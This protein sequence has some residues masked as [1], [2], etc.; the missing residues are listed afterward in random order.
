M[1]LSRL[2]K[3]AGFSLLEMGIVLLIIGMVAGSAAVLMNQ[4]LE[5]AQANETNQKMQ[6]IQKTLLDFRRA[7]NRLP[8]P[9][10]NTLSLMATSFGIEASNPGICTEAN[11]GTVENNNAKGGMLP[12]RTLNLPDDYAFDGWGRRF[13]YAA[14]LRY[15]NTDGFTTF[16]VN[17]GGRLKINPDLVSY[18]FGNTS[19]Y[20]RSDT[21]TLGNWQGTYGSAGYVIPR[22]TAGTNSSYV[23]VLGVTGLITSNTAPYTVATGYTVTPT[24][25][26]H[27]TVAAEDAALFST[28]RL[29]VPN[30][31]TNNR[32]AAYW[33][34]ATSLSITVSVPVDARVNI[35]IYAHDVDS[36][37]RRQ[38]INVTDATATIASEF[39]ATNAIYHTWQVSGT[40]T[41]TVTRTAGA[42]AVISGIFFDKP[43]YH[44]LGSAYVLVSHGKNGHGAFPRNGGATLVNTGSTN[45]NELVN[46]KCDSA[47][48]ATT[49]GF[50]FSKRPFSTD[51]AA[52]NNTYD[53]IVVS[54]TRAD[55][56]TVN[57]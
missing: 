35:S 46:C 11:Q 55:L 10:N 24:N 22:G 40:N 47:A 20:L 3:K 4:Q 48:G 32:I 50:N 15:T 37:T 41:V 7:N 27:T 45:V 17:A 36:V 9:A 21:T 26:S 5:N 54:A 30:S 2:E 8:C 25:N 49:W 53:D 1:S 33:S 16:D 44:N 18:N 51:P 57:E 6:V 42:N 39:N 29:L 23:S 43:R 14:D 38:T 56:R 13:T 34:Q 19:F 12:V 52:P 28:G 31:I